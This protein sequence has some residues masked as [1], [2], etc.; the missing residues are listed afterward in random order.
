MVGLAA[1]SQSQQIRASDITPIEPLTTLSSAEIPLPSLTPTQPAPL[2]I[3]DPASLSAASALPGLSVSG[4]DIIANGQPIQLYGVNMGDPF[5]ARNPDWYNY[6][7]TDYTTLSQGW[8]ANVVRISI[9]PTQWKNMDHATLLAGLSQQINAALDNGMYVLISYHVIGW[10]DGFYQSAYPGNPPDTYDSSMSVATSFWSAMAQ[11]FGTDTRILFDLWNEPVHPDDFTLYGSDPNPLW[12]V[13]KG[14]YETLIQTVRNKGAQNIVIATGNRWSSWLVGIK[15]N[16]LTDSKVVYAYHK[17]SVEGINTAAEWNKDTGGLIGVKPVI[18]SEWGYEDT[19]AGQNRTW[20]GSRST[21]G[22]PF[23]QWMDSKNLSNLAWMYHHEWT[24]ALLKSDGSTTLYGTFVKGYITSKNGGS[25]PIA[26]TLQSPKG[27]VSTGNSTFTW[28]KAAGASKYA[29]YVYTNATPSVVKYANNSF[30]PT[31]GTAACSYA[32]TLNLPSGS[33]KWAARAGNDLGW[34]G[35]SPWSVFTV[36]LAPQARTPSGK[37]Y[38][39]RPTFT[40]TK[41]VGASSYALYVY[42][43]AT[44]S[45][46]KLASSSFTATCS[47]TLTCSFTPVLNLSAGSYKWAVRSLSGSIWSGYSPWLVFTV[48]APSA[49]ALQAPN[50]TVYTVNPTFTWSKATGAS[51]YALYVYTNNVPAVLKFSSSAFTPTC[52]TSTCSYTPRINLMSGNYKWAMRAG[53][54]LGWSSYSPWSVFSVNA[55]GR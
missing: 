12:P 41:T 4:T 14:H 15:D 55:A 20:P 2:E 9:F 46:M 11:A 33:Y 29:L 35:T 43:N 32:P 13:L 24:P 27:T 42:T 53:N 8:R 51:K 5:W 1:P 30:T 50:G 16:P 34:S 23:T 52:G 47:S 21:Y 49:P 18:V 28:T 3:I 39:G 36:S 25:I 45:S 48:S 44:P 6:S 54:T 31:C 40:W 19:D 10:P 26:P 37:V 7:L 22:D 17:Y 38:T